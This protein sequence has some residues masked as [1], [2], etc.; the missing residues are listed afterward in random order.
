MTLLLDNP[1]ADEL[2]RLTQHARR[3]RVRTMRDFAE[4]EIIIPDGPYRGTM[5][6]CAT[7]PYSGLWFDEID[8]GRWR[9]AVATGPSQS[10]KTLTCYVVPALY[11]LFELAE[12]A[13]LG[14]P[15]MEMAADKW[16]MDLLPAIEASRFADLL[17]RTGAGSKG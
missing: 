2:R 14:L 8:S 6:R 13:I 5:F 1:T 17:P 3:P 11:H 15:S 4:A 16:R 10:G 9:R 7:Q 12:T